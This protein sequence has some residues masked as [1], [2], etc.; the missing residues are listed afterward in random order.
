[1]KKIIYIMLLI[2]TSAILNSAPLVNVPQFITQPNGDSFNCLASGDE[3]FNYLHDYNGYTII[4]DKKTGYY[5]YAELSGD[6]LIPSTILAGTNALLPANIKPYLKPSYKSIKYK[7]DRILNTIGSKSKKNFDQLNV[8]NTGTINNLVI[9]IRFS[10]EVE[11]TDST[12][13]YNRMLNPITGNT[14]KNYFTEASYGQLTI[15]STLYPTSD[16]SFVVSYQDTA[17][18]DFFR[19]YSA[20]NLIGYQTDAQCTEREHSLLVRAV[21][22][23]RS[24]IPATLNI[25]NDNDEKVDNVCFIVS[26][27][28]DGW[29]D[30]LW[31]HRWSLYSQI[32]MINTKRVYDYNFQLRNS[33]MS[34]GVGV[35]CHEMF[36][37]LGSPDLYHYNYDGMSPVGS[38]DLMEYNANPPQHMSAYMKSKYGDWIANIPEITTNGTYTLNP[39]TSATNNCYKIASTAS[40]SQYYVVEYRR[41]IGTFESSIPGSGLIVYRINPNYNGNASGPPDEV[42]AYRPNGTISVNGTISS[43]NFSSAEG[44]T[45]INAN[46]NPSPFLAD[47]SQGGLNITQIGSAG[48]TISFDVSFTLMVPTL[49]NPLNNETYISSNTGLNWNLVYGAN[50]Y[51]V[52]LASDTLFAN[53]ISDIIVSTNSYQLN[54]LLNSTNYFWRVKSKN[55]NDSSQWSMIFKFTTAPVGYLSFLNESFENISYPPANWL[56]IIDNGTVNWQRVS[57]GTN[58]TCS[59]I[60]G[61]AMLKYNSYNAENNSSA[62]LIS[63]EL[64]LSNSININLSFNIYREAGYSS[65]ADRVLVYINNNESIIGAY[66]IATIN[67]STSLLPITSQTGW[68]EYLYQIPIQYYYANAHII[69]VSISA[70]GNSIYMD[71]IKLYGMEN[72]TISTVTL[73]TP[74]N[75]SINN[76]VN[77][78]FNWTALT[79]ASSYRIELSTNNSFTNNLI[80]QT[81]SNNTATIN[82]NYN[83][84]Y[85]WR[86]KAYNT[87]D[88]GAWSD[89]F[90]FT[91]RQQLFTVSGQI[92]YANTAQT[93]M[94]NCTII[95]KNANNI[96]IARDTSNELGAYSFENVTT[97]TYNFELISNKA[98]GGINTLDILSLRQKIAAVAE[99]TAIQDKAADINNDSNVSTIDLLPLR[100]KISNISPISSWLVPNYV[101]YPLTVN[102]NGANAILNIQALCGGDV[103]ASFTPN[104]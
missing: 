100:Q 33:L 65:N 13:V 6:T 26:G 66:L 98:S 87:S 43:A 16:N 99:F 69:F 73:T 55:T 10:D 59:P 70:Y 8:S 12:V 57:A 47:G 104:N 58:P 48:E 7:Y 45:A 61:S 60:D 25:D 32:I 40:A 34:S 15:N 102:V 1:M 28:S 5:Y 97:G 101:F 95:L 9:F 42:Y 84:L 64:N 3:F 19:P 92:N 39:L 86:V 53:I 89:V 103:N 41:D 35:L 21:T 44:R 71:K 54:A 24:Q 29:S 17:P 50:T 85:Y 67:R 11:F 37:S 91:T 63:P 49:T 82:T 2:I 56:S 36:H 81:V 75:N 83:T 90:H 76:S 74:L 88:S 77:T 23:V 46:T 52:Q 51:R 38:W 96:E 20:T 27:S 68:H 62:R 18:R 30:L 72:P 14:M 4:Q 22:G 80:S 94:N 78:T 79:N 93:P 31:P